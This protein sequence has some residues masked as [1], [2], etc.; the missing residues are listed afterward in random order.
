MVRSRI[1]RLKERPDPKKHFELV[2]VD[3]PDGE[4]AREK[5]AFAMAPVGLTMRLASRE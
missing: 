5:L 2:A 3:T 4:M 1:Y